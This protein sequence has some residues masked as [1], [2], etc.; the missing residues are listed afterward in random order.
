MLG[1]RYSIGYVSQ[2]AFLFNESIRNNFLRNCPEASESE[3]LEVLKLAACSDFLDR[4][5]NGIDT[6]IGGSGT[7]L[8]GG[9]R[10]RIVLARALSG[11]PSILILDEATSA[12]DTENERKIQHAIESLK[13]QITIVVIAHRL[14]T[15]RSADNI[16][17]IDN[18]SIVEEGNFDQLATNPENF[19][20][21]FLCGYTKGIK[22][23]NDSIVS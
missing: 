5:P 13:G 4:I 8:S 18:G 20:Y 17:V 1:W 23:S 12:L 22:L 7:R 14:S 3:L 2:D 15:I 10:Q 21:S 19:F 6:I 11:N 16:I 9:E